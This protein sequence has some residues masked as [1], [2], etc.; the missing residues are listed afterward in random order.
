MLGKLAKVELR[1]IWKTE[2]QGFTPWL[3]NEEN[4]EL[5]GDTIG[6]ELELVAQEKDVGPF[7]ADILCKNTEDDSWV[8]IENQIEKTD[9][10]H[11]GQLMT[12]AAGLQAVTIVWVAS[13]FT[14]EIEQHLIG[15]IKLLM[16]ILDFL[17]WKLSY[18]RLEI[19]QLHLNL[20]LSASLIIGAKQ[21]H[22][23]LKISAMELSQKL[24]RCNIAI[25]RN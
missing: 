15:L 13:K 17:D 20:I 2:D 24:K 21:Y 12:Y 19:L 10:K 16:I 7:R 5:L 3:A 14:E 23:Q 1:K 9:H 6:I 18:G 11:L 22:K 4:L 8:L 25:G